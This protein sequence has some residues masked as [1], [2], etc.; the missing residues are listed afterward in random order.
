MC[1]R[2]ER[3]ASHAPLLRIVRMLCTPARAIRRLRV[4][5]CWCPVATRY[6]SEALSRHIQIF[7]DVYMDDSDQLGQRYPRSKL[8]VQSMDP[9]DMAKLLSTDLSKSPGHVHLVSILRHL[10]MLPGDSKTWPKHVQVIDE[11]VQQLCVQ[12][13]TGDDPDLA[14]LTSIN[15]HKLVD[16]YVAQSEVTAAQQERNAAVAAQEDYKARCKKAEEGHENEKI[17][18]EA[19]KKSLNKK[20]SK[21]AK[22]N[23]ELQQGNDEMAAKLKELE[24]KLVR[25]EH[26]LAAALAAKPGQAPPPPYKDGA[27]AVPNMPATATATVAPP[28]PPPPLPGSNG[29]APPPPPPPPMPG[30]AGGIP[31][32]P[33]PM[34]GMG[35]GMP[36]MP[37]MPAPIHL[38]PRNVPKPSSQLKSFNWAK[39]GNQKLPTSMW[40]DLNEERA[41][42][43][44]DHKEFEQRFS[45][46]QRKN[47]ARQDGAG[48]DSSATETL[49]PSE[50]SVIDGRRAQNCTI[51]LMNLK[52]TNRKIHHAILSLDEEGV[53]SND[54]VEQM[55]KYVPSPEEIAMLKELEAQVDLFSP[56]DR[57]MWEMNRIPRYEQRL[58]AMFF[59]RKLRERLDFIKP[60][61]ESA[62]LAAQQVLQSKGL[63]RLLELTL[64][65]GNYM[66]RGARGGAYGFQ[67]KSLLSTVDTKSSVSRDY[68]LLHYM[69]ELVDTKEYF[70]PTRALETSLSNVSGGSKV[71]L[72]ELDKEAS[73][74]RKGFKELETELN[75]QKTSKGPALEGDS[76]TDVVDDF[77]KANKREFVDIEQD[78]Q[79][80]RKEFATCLVKFSGDATTKSEPEEFFGIFEQFLGLVDRARK[81]NETKRRKEEEEQR[82]Q[83]AAASEAERI[84]EHKKR[85]SKA[86]VQPE[87]D[88]LITALKSGDFVAPSPSRIAN[89]SRLRATKRSRARTSTQNERESFS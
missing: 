72:V 7:E 20:V 39:I 47:K 71:N 59:M 1:P 84:R 28:P 10:V 52:M 45:A 3:Q 67:I 2:R 27:G 12:S 51:V 76:F 30:Q 25:S 23:G 8:N 61:C 37:G 13:Q 80:M 38:P 32:P 85:H 77:I 34:P 83:A 11:V 60:R 22:D 58:K 66:N 6:D 81:E 31:P 40:L 43:S 86:L 46:F 19:L 50:I 55:I 74:V 87:L 57:F 26:Q 44:I 68:T 16:H 75:L 41:H 36:P 69:I 21:L 79:A 49:R 5:R 54:I 89:A 33:P 65:L 56:A 15:V 53:L 48:T 82:K 29:L 24:A 42:P 14:P 35:A 78:M 63:H 62:K 17:D 18:K 73:I 4:T 9:V 88:D 64:A 70:T